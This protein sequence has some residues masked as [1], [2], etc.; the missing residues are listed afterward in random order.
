MNSIKYQ[1]NFQNN[2]LRHKNSYFFL[3][4]ISDDKYLVF[5][6]DQTVIIICE[7]ELE[8]MIP[9]LYQHKNCMIFFIRCFINFDDFVIRFLND[10][11]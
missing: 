6:F 1:I 4:K 3:Y 8:I 10:R 7:S 11:K 2:I 5:C 9:F